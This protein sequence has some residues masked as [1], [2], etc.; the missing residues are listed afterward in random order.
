MDIKAYI[1][2]FQEISAMERSQQFDIL[3]QARK[4]AEAHFHLKALETLQPLIPI[5]LVLAVAALLY[6]F[7]SFTSWLPIVALLV[8]LLI[9]RVLVKELEAHLM[10]KGLKRVLARSSDKSE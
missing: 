7:W 9:S 4:E 2:H 10:A 3:E 6:V 1:D 8:G 5:L